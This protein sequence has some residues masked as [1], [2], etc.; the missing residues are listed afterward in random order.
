MIQPQR[1]MTVMLADVAG[2][3]HLFE[4]LSDTDAA[5]AMVRCLRL[6]TK[7][8]E[9]KR[10]RTV[11]VSGDELLA[12][13][14]SSDD[15]CQA[16]V[17]MQEHITELAPL[18]TLKLAIRIGLHRGL[19]PETGSILSCVTV[20][21]AARIAGLA[22]P[23]QILVSSPLLEALPGQT[24]NNAIF[25]PLPQRIKEGSTSLQLFEITWRWPEEDG[26]VPTTGTGMAASRLCIRYHDNTY[27]LDDDNAVLTL[28]RDPANALVI[29]ERKASR[30]HG[31]IERRAA[32]YFYVDTSSNGSFV[33]FSGQTESLLRNDEILL[34]G[35][36][37]ICF[38]KS[39]NDASADCIEFEQR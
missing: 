38:G 39:G 32:G 6:M 3:A 31:R 37:R 19:L 20:L 15:A 24:L 22:A 30:Q 28:G 7:C 9:G 36:G 12:V 5:D 10:G 29:A 21:S 26:V 27:Y 25:L 34:Q 17:D 14:A 18:G 2:S 8:I 13:F 4:H 11:Q 23:A 16:A 35:C 33:R 1:P